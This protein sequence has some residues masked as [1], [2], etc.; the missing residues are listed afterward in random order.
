MQE[1]TDHSVLGNFN[2]AK[3][4]YAGITS[5]FF[6]RDGK[7]FVSTD[8]A[9]G[10]L[11]EYPIKYTFGVAPLQQYLIGFADGRLQGLTIAWD[12][13][14]K[15]QGGERWFHLYPDERITHD[16][17]LHWTRGLQNWNFMC[18]DCHSTDVRKNYDAAANKFQTRWSEINVGCEACHGPGSRHLA[19]ANDKRLIKYTASDESKGLNA[20]LD[21]RRG[22][23]WTPNPTNGNSTR[24]KPRASE[25]EIEVCAQCHARR[26]QFAEGY[27]AGEPFLDYYRPALLTSP[28]YYPDGQPSMITRRIITTGR[29]APAPHASPATCQARPTWASIRAPITA[30]AS[31]VRTCR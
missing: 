31:R 12:A 11:A 4:N 20:R 23:V 27:Q 7:F 26:G 9:D 29:P 10:R 14:P 1:A 5:T 3:F 22:V 6:K 15:Q 18:A 8:G 16:D 30:C 28:L 24:S 2:S 21:E 25:R 19:W 17:E 13:R